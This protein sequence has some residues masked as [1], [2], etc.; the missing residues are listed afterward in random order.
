VSPIKISGKWCE[1]DTLQDLE[2]SKKKFLWN[3]IYLLLKLN[4]IYFYTYSWFTSKS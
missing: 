4:V 3:F 1:I 2:N